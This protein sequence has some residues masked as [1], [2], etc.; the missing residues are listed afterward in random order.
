MTLELKYL[1]LSFK[2]L[3][4]CIQDLIT[5]SKFF[6]AAFTPSDQKTMSKHH[7]LKIQKAV[8]HLHL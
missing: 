6:F 3:L 4:Y 7:Q 5:K 1:K 8:Y 2:I